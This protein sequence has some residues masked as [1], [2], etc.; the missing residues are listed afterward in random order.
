[1][2]CT[3]FPENIKG[4]DAAGNEA[5]GELQQVSTS[6]D[7]RSPLINNLKVDL[8][9]KISFPMGNIIIVLV[10]LPLALM[11]GRRKAQSFVALGIAIGVG[12]FYH[13]FN[14]VMLAFG[15]GGLFPPIVAAWM[16]PAV[17]SLFAYYLIKTKF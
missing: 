17:F 12:F 11:T 7:T 5:I 4:K 1:M 8:H 10:G 15:K 6:S 14:V 16:A 2:T 3:V 9:Q 13:L